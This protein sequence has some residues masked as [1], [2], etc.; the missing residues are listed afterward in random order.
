[1]KSL[2][3]INLR[4]DKFSKAILCVIVAAVAIVPSFAYGLDA[5]AAKAVRVTCPHPHPH[6]INDIGIGNY[7]PDEAFAKYVY[8]DI[9][10]HQNWNN[11]GVNYRITGA[12]VNAIRNCETI[13]VSGRGCKDIRG[14]EYFTHLKYLDC[15]DNDFFNITDVAYCHDLETLICDHNRIGFLNLTECPHLKK[16]KCSNNPLMSLNLNNCKELQ[17]VDCSETIIDFLGV[18]NCTDIESINISNCNNLVELNV[19]GNSKIRFINA[20][21]CM[22]LAWIYVQAHPVEI[23]IMHSPRIINNLQYLK[24]NFKP[25]DKVDFVD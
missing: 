15:S 20:S 14:I 16:L 12:D 18:S 17:E 8:E 3:R 7:F 24:S 21:Y 22:N 11:A 23:R 2:S 10:G 4:V 5:K 6:A 19:L 1:M 13:N 25:G 9:L